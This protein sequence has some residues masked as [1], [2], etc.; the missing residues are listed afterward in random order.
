MKARAASRALFV[1]ATAAGLTLTTARG[2]AKPEAPAPTSAPAHESPF[3]DYR[4]QVPG[5]S[6]L[7]R[8]GDLPAPD[9]AQSIDNGPHLVA[10][11]K[12]ALPQAPA[13][14]QVQLYAEGLHNP[15]LIR[16][17]PN[18]DVF[19]VES[20]HDGVRAL[21]GVTA[22]GKAVQSTS[23]AR[24]LHQPFGMVFYPPGPA[25]EPQWLYVANTDSVVRFPYRS[26]DL[27]ARGKPQVVVPDLPGGGL[28]RGGGH[29]TRDL[30]FSRDGMKMYVSVGS[31]SNV[32]DPDTTSAEFHRADILEFS[33]DGGG[34]VAGGSLRVFASGIRN[35]VG[36]AVNPRTG[37][38]WAS[39][40]ERDLLGDDLPP[41][42]ITTVKQ[43]GFY[44]WPWYYIGDHQDPRHAGKHPELRSKVIVP[45]V[46]LQPHFASLQMCFYEGDQFP[47]P[48]RGDIFAAEHGSWNRHRRTGY[49]VIRVPLHGKD[50]ATGEYEDFLTGFVTANGDVWGRPVGVAVAKDGALL[51]TDDG[52]E[53]IWRVTATG[54]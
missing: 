19:V 51:V 1:I 53:S 36:I 54:K 4:G 25:V 28:L 33:L 23:Y 42:Y 32:D 43:G 13:G 3:V 49:E 14:F 30:A 2:L 22:E 15:R 10:R 44:G 48:Y 46:L 5:R 21:R 45:D 35:A 31:R 29:W 8:V 11:P 24:G 9:E 40:N 18:G 27:A 52:S 47:A 16:V 38:L 17:A 39:V 7:V 37:D 50:R 34:L 6:H 26:G 41:D 20:K 12:G